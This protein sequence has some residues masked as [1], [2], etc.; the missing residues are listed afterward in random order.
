MTSTT[1]APKLELLTDGP[2]DLDSLLDRAARDLHRNMRAGY[3][4]GFERDLKDYL[5]G[6]YL[7]NDET[8]QRVTSGLETLIETRMHRFILVDCLLD[9]DD[10]ASYATTAA[11]GD[12]LLAA[13]RAQSRE[14]EALEQL[15]LDEIC[16]RSRME[17]VVQ[18]VDRSHVDA[19]IG[20][21]DWPPVAQP[22]T[23]GC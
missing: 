16:D 21:N 15:V 23:G 13:I 14:Y 18:V 20:E 12:M 2:N 17:S 11:M 22:G 9:E 8:N 7:A 10:A 5:L 6:A 19:V 4:P 3:T 1:A